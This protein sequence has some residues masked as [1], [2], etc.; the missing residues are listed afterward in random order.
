MIFEISLGIL[1]FV[2]IFSVSGRTEV[3]KTQFMSKEEKS[4][5]YTWKANINLVN[6]DS[7][8]AS[9]ITSAINIIKKIIATKEFRERILNYQYKGKR[10]FIDNQ[11][12]T[13]EEIYQ[14][15]MDGAEKNGD[16]K[17]NNMMDVELE[18]Y[19]Q[20]TTTIGYTYPDTDRI[21]INKKY[22]NQYTAIKIADNLMHEWMHKLG[23]THSSKWSEDREHSVPYAIGYLIEEL[24]NKP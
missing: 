1:I 24:A 15:I 6:F 14:I 2:S 10:E 16:I 22:F 21:W 23:F 20:P 9:K 3:H 8:Q 18:L 4:L 11:G 19:F 7:S 12:L 17:K 13:N 5:P